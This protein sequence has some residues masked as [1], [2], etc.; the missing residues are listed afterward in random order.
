MRALYYDAVHMC[1]CVCTCKLWVDGEERGEKKS[2][3]SIIQVRMY[4]YYTHVQGTMH[5]VKKYIT[6]V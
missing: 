2:T 1:V 3:N 4:Y 5:T 6:G